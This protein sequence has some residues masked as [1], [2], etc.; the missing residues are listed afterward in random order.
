MEEV[1]EELPHQI[2][3]FCFK[4]G[5]NVCGK[6]MSSSPQVLR[7]VDH[8]RRDLTF[9]ICAGKGSVT[10]IPVLA[11]RVRCLNFFPLFGKPLGG[12]VTTFS[13]VPEGVGLALAR[14]N[15]S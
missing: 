13:R 8:Q 11:F 7:G 10:D 4:H 5:R 14:Q 1:F 15:S 9:C 6:L 3:K 2:F 12:G